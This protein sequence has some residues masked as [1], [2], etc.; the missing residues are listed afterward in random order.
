[1]TEMDFV[2]AI[3]AEARAAAPD[4]DRRTRLPAALLE[5]IRRVH[6]RAVA[7]LVEFPHWLLTSEG[8]S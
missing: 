8:A 5:R 7:N 4:A 2:L 6:G 1:M 3:R